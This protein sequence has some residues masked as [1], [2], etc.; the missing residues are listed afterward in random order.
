MSNGGVRPGRRTRSVNMLALDT[1]CEA[2]IG[3]HNLP[4]GKLHVISRLRAERIRPNGPHSAARHREICMM[5]LVQ[6]NSATDT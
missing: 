2:A 5:P 3:S 4:S 1:P 6:K